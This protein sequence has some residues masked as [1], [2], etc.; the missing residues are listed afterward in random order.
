[1]R[2]EALAVLAGPCCHSPLTL[3]ES[4]EARGEIW[5][6]ELRCTACER[7]YAIQDGMPLLYLDDDS[8]RPKA[9]EAE[10]WVTF[11]K[12]LGFYDIPDGRPI[13]LDIPYALE[14]P[15]ISVARSFDIGLDLLQLSG[16]ETILD[17]GAGR[18]WASKA[19][20]GQGCAV[21]A[22]DVVTDANVG[23]GRAKALMDD[24]GVY[25]ER[26][27]ADGENLPLKPESFDVVFAAAA[28]HHSSNLP[29][30]LSEAAL[31]LK[32]GGRLLAIREPCISIAES[33]RVIL[34]RDAGDETSVGINETRP[35]LIQY[36]DALAGAG[37]RLDRA[38][39]AE[40][41]RMKDA[42]LEAWARA[43]G[44]TA[45]AYDRHSLRVLV[46]QLRAHWGPRWRALLRGYGRRAG[47][48]LASRSRRQQLELAQLLWSSGDAILLAEKP[49]R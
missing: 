49:V 28:L 22:L 24:A 1:M 18:G 41:F 46:G 14:E 17:L 40:A 34:A 39:S 48:V 8:W 9:I 4:L 45:P 23:L 2:A 25:F 15:W 5:Q 47:D 10:G 42:E 16:H 20:T 13:D 36:A 31:V 6:G 7:A 30:L 38:V 26:L 44:A 32:P 29:R 3:T 11:H 37:L 43:L 27:I 19:F 35:N 21:F 12:N 33:E